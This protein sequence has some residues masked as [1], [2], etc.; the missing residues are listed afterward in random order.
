MMLTRTL[1][2]GMIHVELACAMHVKC[3]SLWKEHNSLISKGSTEVQVVDHTNVCP[4]HLLLLWSATCQQG[5]LVSMSV[6]SPYRPYQF[7]FFIIGILFFKTDVLLICWY[8]LLEIF[9]IFGKGAHILLNTKTC[10]W[11]LSSTWPVRLSNHHGFVIFFSHSGFAR[12]ALPFKRANTHFVRPPYRSSCHQSRGRCLRQPHAYCCSHSTICA[13]RHHQTMERGWLWVVFFL[14]PRRLMR[15]HSYADLTQLSASSLQYGAWN[16]VGRHKKYRLTENHSVAQSYIW[17][18]LSNVGPTWPDGDN[19]EA[20]YKVS[21]V[22]MDARRQ[23]H[24]NPAAISFRVWLAAFH[25]VGSA[26][27]LDTLAKIYLSY[28]IDLVRQQSTI[29]LD[30]CLRPY[31]YHAALPTHLRG[32]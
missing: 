3:A 4:L 22:E 7:S 28:A 1:D 14:E 30:H 9:N 23:W 10:F 24:D 12:R 13:S 6:S 19:L 21:V 8:I 16:C 26:S 5:Y 17:S 11:L 20:D 27:C 15:N 29:P 31:F 18:W 32:G 25:D 2:T